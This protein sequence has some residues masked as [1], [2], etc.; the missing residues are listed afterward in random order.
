MIL[1]EFEGDASGDV[2]AGGGGAPA[3][4]HVLDDKVGAG[5]VIDVGRFFGVVH[6]VG[7]IPNQYDL[8]PLLHELSDAEGATENAH[9]EMDAHDEDVFDFMF[10]EDVEGLLAV[11]GDEVLGGDFEGADLAFPGLADGAGG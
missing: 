10:C 3:L 2:R 6:G 11:I 9:V 1:F 7:E 5:E 8:L 4:F